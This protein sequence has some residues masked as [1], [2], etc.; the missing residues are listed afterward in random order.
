MRLLSLWQPWASF[1]AWGFKSIETRGWTT[2]YRGP[3]AIH[4]AKDRRAMKDA[5]G[6]LHDAGFA[7]PAGPAGT[8]PFGYVVAVGDL[9]DAFKVV[10]QASL[11]VSSLR[12]SL[13]VDGKKHER[14]LAA[15]DEVTL[16]AGDGRAFQ[17]PRAETVL[18]NLAAGRVG[19]VF[20]NV[21][22]LRDPLPLR[23][24]QGLRPVE[25]AVAAEILRRVA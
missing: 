5:D 12:M 13:T 10:G 17:I 9:V 4:A 18:G 19:L 1:M 11:L 16:Y 25:A 14:T 24:E 15:R 23:G 20:A 7:R 22:P 6:L 21:R 3:V 2:P 8:Y